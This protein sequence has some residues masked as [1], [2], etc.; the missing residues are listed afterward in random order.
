MVVH[1]P[2]N[3]HWVDKDASPWARQYL[4]DTIRMINVEDDGVSAKLVKLTSM[5]GDVDVIQ[6]KGKVI[7]IYDVK[8]TIEYS[9]KTKDN[10]EVSGTIKIPEIA[11]DT[12]EDDY[13][14]DIDINTDSASK[15]PVRDL[16]KNKIIPILR[17]EFR[18]LGPAL[19]D[20]IGKDIQHSTGPSSSQFTSSTQSKTL[21]PPHTDKTDKPKAETVLSF[22]KVTL[23]FKEEFMARATELYSTFTD[24]K[25]LEAL[26]QAK[27]EHFGGAVVGGRF[28]IAGFTGE[29]TELT[30][31]VKIVQKWRFNYWPPD[32][33]S[34][35]E[36]L[37]EQND[38]D[39]V[40]MMNVTWS[41]VPEE[42]ASA[43]KNYWTRYYVHAIK[44]T[45][46]YGLTL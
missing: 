14:F 16:V 25:R 31:P 19:R 11:H 45:F 46:G 29:F 33:Y 30:E 34:S 24:P 28:K 41:G 23:S 20:E 8:L 38:R 35:I 18:K 3:W 21:F 15:A 39:N 12:E 22:S 9:G 42:Q 27:H 44:K 13:V 2:N 6:R 5:D 32:H 40:T 17:K 10:E 37:F 1:N 43:V 7:T 4:E 36:M 26:F